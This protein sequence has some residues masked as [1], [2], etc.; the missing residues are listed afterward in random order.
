MLH[1][2]TCPKRQ[3]AAEEAYKT[4]LVIRSGE[5]S[6]AKTPDSFQKPIGDGLY[7]RGATSGGDLKKIAP[8][9]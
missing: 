9:F 8:L 4:R 7:R 2:G 6:V 1:Q 5:G 3:V